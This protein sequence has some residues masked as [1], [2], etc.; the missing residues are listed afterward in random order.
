MGAEL[1]RIETQN[2]WEDIDDS[3]LAELLKTGE[4]EIL[5]SE[6]R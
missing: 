4:V 1:K 3:K 6:T 5:F 2:N